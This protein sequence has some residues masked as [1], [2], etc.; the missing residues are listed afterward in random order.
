[1]VTSHLLRRTRRRAY[2]HTLLAADRLFGKHS[3]IIPWFC[4]WDGKNASELKATG[5]QFLRYFIDVCGVKPD[6][7]ILD[8]GCGI[9][10]IAVPL[11]KYITNRG[12][13]D[14]LDIIPEAIRWCSRKITPRY[15]N[16]RF[17]FANV[18]NQDYNPKGG[19]NAAEYVFPYDDA[20]F[21][22]VFL[23][24]VFTHML[25]HEIGR[26]LFEITRV[27]KVEGKT[28]ITFFLLTPQTR[29]RVMRGES[30]LPF[31]YEGVGFKAISELV[32]EAAVAFDESYIKEQYERCGLTLTAPIRYGTWSYR[33]SDFE[34]QDFIVAEKRPA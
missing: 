26:Y 5:Q 10:R 4:R 13:Y 2:L 30:T 23:G 22:F 1:M 29:A 25:P 28:L 17:K 18:A 3:E 6:A 19:I 34:Y 32:P 27:L 31:I 12:S 33:F 11:T 15:P 24:S 16:F 20:S 8:V 9:G 14:G 7:H 21:D